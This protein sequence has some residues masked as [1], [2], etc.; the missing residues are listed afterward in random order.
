L[1]FS[2]I[3]GY[4]CQIKN[5]IEF[6]W[7]KIINSFDRKSNDNENHTRRRFP[8]RAIDTCAISINGTTY[9]IKDWSKTGA[10]FAA[11]GRLFEENATVPAT[12]KFRMSDTVMEVALSARIIRAHAS[13]VA[14]EFLNVDHDTH[15]A[16]N[17]VIDHAIAQGFEEEKFA[18]QF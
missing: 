9:P 11:D 4:L 5:G 8:R 15:Q 1:T 7:K 2:K 14:L 13:G 12:M 6:M 3:S 17:R 10:L 16:F 18:P